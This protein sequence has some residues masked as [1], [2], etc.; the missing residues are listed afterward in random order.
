[1]I[2]YEVDHYEI[3]LRSGK[4]N[5]FGTEEAALAFAL[6]HPNEQLRFRKILNGVFIPSAA[7]R[8]L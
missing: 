8:I 5:I 6:A 1:M 4:V 7:K 2:E 3:M